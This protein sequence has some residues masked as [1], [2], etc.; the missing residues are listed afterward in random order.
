MNQMT[1]RTRTPALVHGTHTRRICT[2]RRYG[3]QI[4]WRGFD[5]RVRRRVE[6]CTSFWAAVAHLLM[7]GNRKGL[8]RKAGFACLPLVLSLVVTTTYHLGY[9]EYRGD[10]IK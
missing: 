5:L 6:R 10:T 9:S 2:R 8:S 3:F 4:M 1:A 7:R